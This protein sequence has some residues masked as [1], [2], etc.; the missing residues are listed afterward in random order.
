MKDTKFIENEKPN[1]F[2]FL[3][4]GSVETIDEHFG[5][6]FSEWSGYFSDMD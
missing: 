2:P 5:K 1:T 6:A 4:E 3:L